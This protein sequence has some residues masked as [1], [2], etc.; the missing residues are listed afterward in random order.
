MSN[1]RIK[2]L[3]PIKLKDLLKK[4]GLSLK[5]FLKNMGIATHTTLVQQ[6]QSMGVSYPSEEEFKDAL[7]E[8]VSSP[9]EGVVVL[10]PPTLIKDSGQKINIDEFSTIP[11][12]ESVETQDQVQEQQ[13]D[14]AQVPV[15]TFK[16]TTKKTY[17]S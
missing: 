11:K 4:R 14:V 7:G 15:K 5:D 10:D 6:C 17:E 16:R 2:G 8:V 1:Y 9:Q 3:P 12:Q 13:E